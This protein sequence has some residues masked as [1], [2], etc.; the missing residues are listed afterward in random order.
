MFLYVLG[1]FVNLKDRV[2]EIVVLLVVVEGY[3]DIIKELVYY[4]VDVDMVIINGR[5]FFIGK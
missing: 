4:K 2:G 3:S 1:V 5:V